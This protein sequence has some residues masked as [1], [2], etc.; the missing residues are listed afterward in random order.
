MIDIRHLYQAVNDDY[1]TI[2]LE[3][4]ASPEQLIE[5][6]NYI[7]SRLKSTKIH[8]Y[9]KIKEKIFDLFGV[10]AA[11]DEYMEDIRFHTSEC[12]GS[13]ECMV[14]S[15]IATSLFQSPCVINEDSWVMIS[16][17]NSIPSDKLSF[18]HYAMMSMIRYSGYKISNS[19]IFYDGTNYSTCILQIDEPLL[20]TWFSRI[21]ECYNYVSIN[22]KIEFPLPKCWMYPNMKTDSGFWNNDKK[23]FALSCKELTLLWY[24]TPKKRDSLHTIH[25]I[26]SY[27]DLR[28]DSSIVGLSKSTAQIFDNI[29]MINQS[30]TTPIVYNNT[31][32]HIY[33]LSRKVFIDVEFVREF[34]YMIGCYHEDAYIS[35]TANS[36][37]YES[38]A[39]ILN[40][41][42]HYFMPYEDVTFI[43]WCVEKN[44]MSKKI[45]MHGDSSRVKWL[46]EH[47]RWIDL[48]R[49]LKH[50]LFA[51][52]GAY[53]Y[54]LKSITKA[55]FDMGLLSISIPE[56]GPQNGFDSI[57]MALDY[58][59]LKNP[60]IMSKIINYNRFDCISMYQ[61][62]EALM[63]YDKKKCDK[64]K[65]P[66]TNIEV[67]VFV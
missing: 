38:E 32:D 57:Q 36:L 60:D 65:L 51:I 22:N 61:I 6:K 56:E 66:L 48:C 67:P 16:A 28:L 33:N 41:F 64:D 45:E 19:V 58:Y 1:F 23:Q 15:R 63:I 42:V 24:I 7:Y 53:D 5:F 31:F 30:I 18:R 62:I 4:S 46:K 37:D 12:H 3:K 26:Y 52:N 21:D 35:F 10:N 55:M 27:D 25:K 34:V 43:Y 50:N 44:V 39:T 40:D 11:R 14:T 29:V 20:K 49:E 54:K 8:V 59:R 13:I 9:D 47:V 2:L 17:V